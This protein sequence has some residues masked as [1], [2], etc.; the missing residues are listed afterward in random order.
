MN[1]NILLKNESFKARCKADIYSFGIILYEIIGRKGPWG[2]L[3]DQNDILPDK[4][5][6]ANIHV[7]TKPN[8]PFVDHDLKLS[9]T[10]SDDISGQPV[11]TK[12]RFN[13]YSKFE[14]SSL[15]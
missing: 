6:F 5:Y 9:W 3:I 15:K 7:K 4:T 14:Y 2:E 8:L 10:R 12:V 1:S 13:V 11:D